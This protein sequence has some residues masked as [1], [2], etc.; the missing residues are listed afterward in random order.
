[1][2]L[3]CGIGINDSDYKVIHHKGGERVF[4]CPFYARWSHMLNR[5][6]GGK[7]HTARPSY[8]GCSV[9][10]TWLT[11]S[12]FRSWMVG[13]NWQGKH[14][15][16]DILVLGNKIYGPNYCV[17]VDSRVNSFIL[18][19]G[20]NPS[21]LRGA[22]WHQATN[23]FRAYGWDVQTGKRKTVGSFLTAEEAHAAWLTFK[24]N[25]AKILAGQQSDPRVAEA[26][27]KRFENYGKQ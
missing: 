11:F 6:Y 3:V 25:Q 15:D 9:D 26:L 23:R 18:D 5:C 19:G 10:P 17:F 27:I 24:I 20:R 22:T 13:E 16:K 4:K 7:Y 2:S 12:A 1:M 21:V 14:L 8:E